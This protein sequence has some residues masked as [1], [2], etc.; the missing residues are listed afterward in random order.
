M[1]KETYLLI[2]AAAFAFHFWWGTRRQRQMVALLEQE[3]P[4]EVLRFK[5]HLFRYTFQ[6]N[7]RSKS[8]KCVAFFRQA[9]S[10]LTF[11]AGVAGV[12][13]MFVVLVLW[14]L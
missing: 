9:Q 2:P 12:L 4:D 13:L 10:E 7:L 8:P 6:G 5:G 1:S 11:I 14:K 3:A